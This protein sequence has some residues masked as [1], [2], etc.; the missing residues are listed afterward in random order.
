MN[1]KPIH[2][3]KKQKILERDDFICKGCGCSGNFNALEV[4]HIIP[5]KDGGTND[6]TNLQT[7]CYKCNMKK[8]WKKDFN[9]NNDEEFS[10]RE[11][12]EMIRQKLIEYSDL[13]WNEF[14]IIFRQEKV[15]KM[16]QVD[17][18]EVYDYFLE[19]KGIDKFSE[20]YSEISL[21][22]NKLIYYLNKRYTVDTKTLVQISGLSLR[23][24]QDIIKKLKKLEN[25][26]K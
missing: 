9:I 15:F 23:S 2:P 22:R 18:S 13:S 7:L 24:I 17:L 19:I 4:D 5:R 25:K 3:R 14:K 20:G 6:E 16:F 12:L 11:R 1:N 8:L 26:I 10:P 21:Q